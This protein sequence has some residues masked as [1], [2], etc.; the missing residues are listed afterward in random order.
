MLPLLPLLPCEVD[1]VD[2]TAIFVF[3]AAPA[4]D[5]A[6]LLAKDSGNSRSPT[7]GPGGGTMLTLPL[8]CLVDSNLVFQ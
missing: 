7:R 1:D 5:V 2:P 4:A 3:L 8:A 6:P